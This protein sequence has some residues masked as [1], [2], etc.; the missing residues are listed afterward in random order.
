MRFACFDRWGDPKP[1]PTGI[2][3][4]KWASGV[5]GTRILELTLAGE[6]DVGKGDRLVFTDPRGVPQ[7]V[8]VVS[9]EHRREQSRIVTNL[10]CKGS[11]RELDDTF[12]ADKRNRSAT[13]RQCL[14][15]ALEGTRWT[16]GHV[17][18]TGA[19]DLSFYHVSVLEAVHAIVGKYGLE[20][21][22]SLLMD[23]DYTRI[24]DRAVNLVTIQGDQNNPRRFEYGHDLKG[25]TRT[26]DASSVK[27][28]LY[29]YGKGLPTLDENGEETGGYGRRIDFSDVNNG[30]P[31]I[32]DTEATHRWGLPGPAV[33]SLGAQLV[34]DPG[35]EKRNTPTWLFS[36]TAAF[37]GA[38]IASD[39]TVKPHN[40]SKMLRM[41]EDT[42]TCA[43]SAVCDA[44]NVNGGSEYRLSLWTYGPAGST[45]RLRVTQ[46]VTMYPTSDITPEPITNNGQWTQTLRRFTVNANTSR[47]RIWLDQPTTVMYVDDIQLNQLTSTRIHPSE[48]IYENGDCEDPTQL[49]AETRA[50]LERRST[51]SISYEADVLSLTRAGMNTTNVALG[52]RVTLVDTTFTPD[53]RLAGRVLR[54]EEDLLDPSL[55]TITI[56]NIIERYTVSARTTEQRLDHM[57]ANA[58]I[59]NGSSQQV[60]QNASKWDQVAQTVIDQQ[61]Q[62]NTASNTVQQHGERWNTAADTVNARSSAWNNAAA[63]L[64]EHETT[65]NQASTT[66][67][68]RQTIWNATQ[69]TVDE[70]APVWDATANTVTNGQHLWNDTGDTLTA[71]QPI[72]DQAAS[73]V[74]ANADS[75]DTAASIATE[76]A[77]I[78][79]HTQTETT[80]QHGT[81]MIILG[82]T[83]S[84]TDTSS[85]WTFTNGAFTKQPEPGE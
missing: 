26:I 41:G 35:F 66:L 5:D 31:Y 24:T 78:I 21:T 37:L 52:D 81:T 74:D 62:W 38:V 9:P 18:D 27:T 79:Q 72:W 36:P 51:P 42:T 60:G 68:E 17:D 65:W 71:R 63:T 48:G 14:A 55:S 10:V 29:G 59:W 57:T 6:S 77:R 76:H 2:V 44:V 13:A 45:I 82:E 49:L 39:N 75:W 23:A 7:E 15:K 84:L 1:E 30:K 69:K 85:T 3:S 54:L 12:I 53:L 83:I 20:I 16:V 25:I 22:T 19:A 32:E 70:R 40:G 4:A 47:I 80:F 58:A 61:H 11:L 67:T 46:N 34:A 64:D 8:I 33:E 50:E 43:T 56:G 28:R 73:T